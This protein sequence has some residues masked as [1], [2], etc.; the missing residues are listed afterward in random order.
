MS[1]S[2]TYAPKQATKTSSILGLHYK[3]H[4]KAAFGVKTQRWVRH[5]VEHL[6]ESGQHPRLTPHLSPSQR[7]PLIADRRPRLPPTRRR[8]SRKPPNKTYFRPVIM[9]LSSRRFKGFDWE[10]RAKGLRKNCSF[11]MISLWENKNG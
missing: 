7:P 10:I 3:R 6:E 11:N 9:S 2:K 5:F 4:H 1:F 8:R